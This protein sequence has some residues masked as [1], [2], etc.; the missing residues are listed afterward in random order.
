LLSKTGLGSVMGF[1]NKATN[2]SQLFDMVKTVMTPRT[3]D[4]SPAAQGDRYNITQFSA[5]KLAEL[6]RA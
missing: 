2:S 5:F 4:T 1:M 6:L 3:N